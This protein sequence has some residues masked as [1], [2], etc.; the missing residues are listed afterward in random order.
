V[1][2][3]DWIIFGAERLSIT[4]TINAYIQ[5]A[6]TSRSISGRN[7]EP[8]VIESSL[9]LRRRGVQRSQTYADVVWPKHARWRCRG[10]WPELQ[11]HFCRTQT[12]RPLQLS[13]HMSRKSDWSGRPYPPSA[14]FVRSRSWVDESKT[15]SC[16]KPLTA[17]VATSLVS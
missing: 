3:S 11:T 7:R 4:W 17:H 5:V 8:T 15:H 1:T 9:S 10:D 2:R 6:V 16:S 14:V 12:P 13:G